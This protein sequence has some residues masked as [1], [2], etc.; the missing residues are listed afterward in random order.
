MYEYVRV[1]VC[2]CV[3]VYHQRC[4]MSGLGSPELHFQVLALALRSP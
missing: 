2:V 1:C 4:L 3:C